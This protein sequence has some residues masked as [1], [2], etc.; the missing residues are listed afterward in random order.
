MHTDQSTGETKH[1]KKRVGQDK[2][3]SR[4]DTADAGQA[5]PTLTPDGWRQEVLLFTPRKTAI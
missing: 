2:L 5:T 4:E 3:G 1:D